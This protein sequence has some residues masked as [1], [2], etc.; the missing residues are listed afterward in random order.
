M[1]D[2]C[3]VPEHSQEKE[4]SWWG[5]G[6]GGQVWDQTC[7]THVEGEAPRSSSFILEKDCPTE[8]R[9]EPQ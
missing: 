2:R 6:Y 7:G 8:S 5:G 1:K 3:E 9:W 4:T